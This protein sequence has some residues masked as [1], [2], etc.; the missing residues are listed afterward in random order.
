ML[1][2][3]YLAFCVTLVVMFREIGSHPRCLTYNVAPSKL[4]RGLYFCPSY[5]SEYGCCNDRRDWQI[6]IRN[7]QIVKSFNL[8]KKSKCTK[9]LGEILCLE[10]H[11]YA[12][13]IFASEGNAKFDI[14]SATP[15]LCTDF[16]QEFFQE[17]SDVVQNYFWKTGKWIPKNNASYAL[18]G[19]SDISKDDFCRSIALPDIDYCYPSVQKVDK[20]IL[21]SRDTQK[22]NNARI[23][24][25]LVASSL[26]NPLAAMH[27][28]DGSNRLFVA[29]QL[30]E[31]HVF[32]NATRPFKEPFLDIKDK[33]LTTANYGDERGFLSLAF[34]P[35]YSTNGRVFVYYS[36]VSD[37]GVNATKSKWEH[38]TVL[39]EFRVSAE[40]PNRLECLLNQWYLYTAHASTPQYSKA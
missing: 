30:G 34:H 28:G 25:E 26:R 13:H 4:E 22:T 20:S 19:S 32:V 38:T 24:A 27:A 14:T 33:V 37:G 23:C 2:L 3:S 8:E 35:N 12:A 11:P 40:N 29:E 9:M 17:C 36:A 16:C 6:S 39:S 7:K 31:V 5:D 15:G 21:G 18:K 1:R 10:C